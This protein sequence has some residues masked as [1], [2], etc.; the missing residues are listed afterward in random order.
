MRDFSMK[1]G[2]LFSPESNLK[3]TFM[4]CCFIAASLMSN[5]LTAGIPDSVNFRILDCENPPGPAHIITPSGISCESYTISLDAVDVYTGTGTWSVVSGGGNII[6]PSLPHT[7]LVDFAPGATMVIRWTVSNEDCPPVFDEI[8]ITVGQPAPDITSNAPVCEGSTLILEITDPSLYLT[9]TWYDKNNNPVGTAS[10]LEIPGITPDQNGVFSVVVTDEYGC[11]T[12]GYQGVEVLPVESADAGADQLLCVSSSTDLEGNVSN[13]GTGLWTLI[14]G[15][16]IIAAPENP[17]T[18]VSDLS[19]GENIF[20]WTITSGFGC[21]ASSDTVVIK[22]GQPAP[23][24]TSNAPVCEGSTLILEITDPSLYLT[25]TWYDKNNNP[26]GTTSSLEIPGITPDQNGVFSVVVTDEYGCETTGYKGIEVLPVESADAGTDQLLCVGSS[27]GLEGNV[28]NFGTGEWTIISGNALIAAPENPGTNVSDL[29]PGENI[30]VWTITSG[31][32]CGPSSDTVVIKVG[33]P[34]PDITSNAPVCEGSTL[35]LEITDPSLYLTFTWYDKNNNPVGT[36]STLE[37]PGITPDQNGVFSVIVTDEYGCET[38]GYKGIEVFPADSADAGADQLLCVGSST[39]LEGNVPNFGTGLWTLISGNAIIAAPENPETNVTDLTPGENIFAWTV[40]SGFGCDPSSDTVVIKVGQPAPDITSNAPVCEGSTLILEITDPSL[41]LTFTWYDTDNNPVGT[42]PTLEI[43]GISIDQNGVFSVVVTDEYGCETTG[44]KGIEVLPVESADAGADQLLCV[45]SSTDLEGNIP[46]FGTGE[47]TIISGNAFIAA[48]GNPG[49]NVTDL[50]PGE[51]IFVW[52][53]TSGFGCDASSDTVVIKVGQPAPDITSNAPVCEGSTLILEITD[54]SLYLTFTWYDTNNNPVGTASTLEIPGITPDQNG[55]FSVVVTDEYGCE[56]T[57]YKGI[58]VLPADSADAGADQLLCAGSSA[59]LAGNI[60]SFG[61]GLWTL[62]SGNAIIAEPEDPGTNVSNLSP[63]E[64]IFVWTVTSGFGCGPSSDTVVIKVGQ[65]AP[66]ITSNAPVCE[67]STLILEITDPSLYLTFTWY[68][69]D[70]NLVGTAP[71]L[72]IPG[73]S[74]DQNGVFSVV[75]TDEYGCETTGYKGIEV[76]P[77]DSADAGVDQLLCVGSST[78]LEGNIPSFGTGLWTLLSGNAIIAAP[79]DPGANVSDLSPGENIF[80][81]TVTSGFGC[82][83]SSDTVVIKVGQP[84]PDITSNAPVCERTTLIF[85]TGDSYV[86]YQWQDPEGNIIGSAPVIEIQDVTAGMAGVYSVFTLDEY[87]CESTNSISVVIFSSEKAV[88]GDDQLLCN[89][90]QTNFNAIVPSNGTGFWN[91]LSGY[92]MIEDPASNNSFISDLGSGE[93]I[94]VWTIIP[95]NGCSGSSDTVII[96]VRQP[97]PF[98]TSDSPVCEGS[99]LT[100]TGEGNQIISYRWVSPNGSITYN[101][102]LMI[103]NAQISD[104]GFYQFEVTDIYGCLADTMIEVNVYPAY[105]ADAG[106]DKFACGNAEITL[107][108][109][110]PQDASGQW[111]ILQGSGTLSDGSDPNSLFVNQP[112]YDNVLLT[113]TLTSSFGCV[114]TDTLLLNYLDQSPP[115]YAGEDF[116]TCISSSSLMLNAQ[117][118]GN[119]QGSWTILEG[120]A[121]IENIN[122]PHTRIFEIAPGPQ[123]IL[124]L[125]WSITDLCH[126]GLPTAEDILTVS[127]DEMSGPAVIL[128]EDTSLC[129]TNELT[130]SADQNYAGQG[131]WSVISGSGTITEPTNPVTLIT[132]ISRGIPVTV[133]WHVVNGVCPVDSASIVIKADPMPDVAIAGPDKQFC[134]ESSVMLEATPLVNGQGI[135]R[136][137]AGSASIEN[138]ND[139]STLLY[140]LLPDEEITL[141]WEVSSGVCPANIDTVALTNYALPSAAIAGDDQVL[142]NSEE[143]VIS[144]A[145][146]LSGVGEWKIIDGTGLI[147]T[148]DLATTTFIPDAPDS[149]N[150]LTWTVSNGICPVSTDT[151]SIIN[152]QLPGIAEAGDDIFACTDSVSLSAQAIEVGTGLWQIIQG[153]GQ[154]SHAGSN[155]ITVTQLLNDDTVT[156]SWNITNGTCPLSSDT[157][158]ITTA[159]NYLVAQAGVDLEPCSEE[160]IQLNA[161]AAPEGA[162]GMWKIISGPG[163]IRDPSNAVSWVDQLTA[164]QETVLTWTLSEGACPEVTD[165]ISINNLNGANI[166]AN[167]LINR[168]GCVGDSLAIIDISNLPEASGIVFTWTGNGIIISTERDPVVVFEES[169]SKSIQLE[170]QLGACRSISPTKEIYLLDCLIYG[171]DTASVYNNVSVFPNPSNGRIWVEIQQSVSE[172]RLMTYNAGGKL[173]HDEKVQ[174]NASIKE[175]DFAE[176]GFYFVRLVNPDFEKTIKV[177]ILN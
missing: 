5:P 148:A 23:D 45:G 169:G 139:P 99:A 122:D 77:A 143:I 66:D 73:I 29:S 144:A 141:V 55:V 33:Q 173:I 177:L 14:S 110:L 159:K 150:T 90:T 53:V 64:N 32:G 26:V 78:D 65:P 62:I 138:V 120:S 100:L 114:D 22:V 34:E 3:L 109:G 163:V 168:S 96:S 24:I 113:W 69:T 20:V 101:Q 60:P 126:V 59:D 103:P 151:V 68:D 27:T 84:A 25:F 128:T 97:A 79:E 155:Q 7:Q 4:T 134:N 123:G 106:T 149:L 118:A 9:F 161:E 67:G 157:V 1:I 124:V 58:E 115:A 104:N 158:T 129:Q 38:T 82:G 44:Y 74:I 46:N 112:P 105:V 12:T 6:D 19:P 116:T 42:A 28:P 162:A 171:Q 71:T 136:L 63:G 88:A 172:S 153:S 49:T 130:V 18:N 52:T 165:T 121:M 175:L 39:D 51:N 107:N 21:D 13:F 85:E 41:Y 133:Q 37:I 92:G 47:W 80:V 16:A 70:N 91:I 75:V 108:A 50:S 83:P 89:V 54:P 176:P 30:F 43:P 167:F 48:P 102:E 15:N 8:T 94:F 2:Y 132:D 142:C 40:T 35:I 11:E 95:E 61:T 93:N 145:E 152:Y 156:I 98:I 127:F 76:F 140:G 160:H 166:S 57:G 135:W 87:G 147:N 125:K 117:A 36:V 164:G 17:G 56:T 146:V 111:N 81:W 131:I 10:S 170:I 154:I 119:G 72:E 86:S 31:F 137:I 174:G